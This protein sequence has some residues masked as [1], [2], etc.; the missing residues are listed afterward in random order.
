M[1]K[2]I[3]RNTKIIYLL[4]GLL[5]SYLITAFVLLILSF[6]MLKMDLSGAVISGGINFVY[7]LSGLAGGFYIGK[8]TEEKRFVWGLAMGVLYFIVLMLISLGLN[9]DN[10][11]P[12]GNYLTVLIISGLSGMLGGMIS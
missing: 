3:R 12:L 10:A 6:L 2:V 7:I 4:E 9:G 5:F 11:L 8:R 1:D